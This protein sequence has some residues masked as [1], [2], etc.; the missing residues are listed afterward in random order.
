MFSENLMVTTKTKIDLR[1]YTKDT[2][3]GL[4][5]YHYRKS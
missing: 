2:K 4:K 5:V 3:K 1:R